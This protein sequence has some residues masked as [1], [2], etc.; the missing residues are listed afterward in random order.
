MKTR[1]ILVVDDDPDIRDSLT[2]ALENEGMTVR[3]ASNG[4]EAL[5][6]LAQE[7]PSLILLDLLMPEMN[8]WQLFEAL[9]ADAALAGV[10]VIVI[11]AA[12]NLGQR[13][14]PG[15][16]FLFKPIKLAMLLAAV[17]EYSP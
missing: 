5:E 11:S 1:S 8:G 6:M 12:P 2:F 3:S 15:T 7:R 16:R 17:E 13:L 9:R 10:P 4:R 14:P